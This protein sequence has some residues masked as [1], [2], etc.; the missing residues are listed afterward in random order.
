MVFKE[1]RRHEYESED[2]QC[3]Q[4]TVT[5]CKW[6]LFSVLAVEWTVAPLCSVLC[7]LHL[8]VFYSAKSSVDSCGNINSWVV[9]NE[10][11]YALVKGGK[12]TSFKKNANPLLFFSFKAPILLNHITSG[13]M[14]TVFAITVMW[15]F[16]F[17]VC[18]SGKWSAMSTAL[19]PQELT[20][21]T[22]TCSWTGSVFI[23][24]RPQV[25]SPP[26]YWFIHKGHIIGTYFQFSI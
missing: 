21:E 25:S 3:L 17:S 26:N 4:W 19:I 15:Y 9:W 12:I 10:C 24:M 6:S 14:C 20:T 2:N 8:K 1:R 11:R 23:I 7:I 22:V 16:P 18:S 13:K 5:A